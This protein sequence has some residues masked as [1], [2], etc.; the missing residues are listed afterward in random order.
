MLVTGEE[1]VDQP[2]IPL[3]VVSELGGSLAAAATHRCRAT[4]AAVRGERT[5]RC[6]HNGPFPNSSFRLYL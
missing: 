3:L 4:S 1:L 6:R 5:S 2:P